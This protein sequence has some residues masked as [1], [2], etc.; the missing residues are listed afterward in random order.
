[1][2]CGEEGLREGGCGG[3]GV[4]MMIL[5]QSGSLEELCGMLLK[6]YYDLQPY[7]DQ[8]LLLLSMGCSHYQGK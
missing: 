2:G 3:L 4:M 7:P 5:G 8:I 1:M 6:E